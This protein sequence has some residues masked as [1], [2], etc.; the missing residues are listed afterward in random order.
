MVY[1]DGVRRYRNRRNN[2]KRKILKRI[3]QSKLN[4]KNRNQWKL[5]NN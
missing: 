5:R 4:K 3:L 2:N 1:D